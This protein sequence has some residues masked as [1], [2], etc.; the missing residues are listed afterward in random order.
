MP[1][2]K[3]EFIQETVKGTNIKY[4]YC[5]LCQTSKETVLQQHVYKLKAYLK[6]LQKNIKQG[7]H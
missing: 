4:S 1:K 3:H 2:C 7:E 6:E 5:H